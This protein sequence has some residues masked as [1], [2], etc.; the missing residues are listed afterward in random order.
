M[1]VVEG[2]VVRRGGFGLFVRSIGDAT[3]IALSEADIV[4]AGLFAFVV[5]DGGWVV[6]IVVVV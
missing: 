2:F 6:Y 3:G 5:V 1:V 4:V